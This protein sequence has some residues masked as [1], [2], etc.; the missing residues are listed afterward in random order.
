MEKYFLE[1]CLEQMPARLELRARVAL[2]LIEKWGTISAQPDGE[3]SSGRQ[4]WKCEPPQ[5]LVNRCFSIAE[6]FVMTG[7][8]LGYILPITMTEGERASALGLLDRARSEARFT[9]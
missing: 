4:K 9:R 1:E 8:S 2:T 6:L 7:V 3:D 5:D